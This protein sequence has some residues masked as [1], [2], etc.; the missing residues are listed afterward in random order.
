[1]PTRRIEQNQVNLHSKK[2]DKD[3][4]MGYELED[5]ERPFIEQLVV[6]C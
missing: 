4:I 6:L 5:L 3:V 2:I 1:M